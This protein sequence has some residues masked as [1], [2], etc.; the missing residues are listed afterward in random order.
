[1]EGTAVALAVTVLGNFEDYHYYYDMY[2]Q[3]RESFGGK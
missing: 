1:M 3:Q 2:E